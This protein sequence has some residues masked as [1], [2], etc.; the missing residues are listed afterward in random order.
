MASLEKRGEKFRLI[1]KHGGRRYTHSLGTGDPK[2]AEALKTRLEENQRLLERGR[3]KCPPGA[4][5]S[6]F[7]LSDGQLTAPSD[8]VYSLSLT[9]LAR[10]YKEAHAGAL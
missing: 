8:A 2:E 10:R 7:L 1:Y 4:D 6:L 3:M 5:L 9:D